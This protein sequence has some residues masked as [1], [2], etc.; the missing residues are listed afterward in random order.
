MLDSAQLAARYAA[1]RFSLKITLVEFENFQLMADIRVFYLSYMLIES[2]INAET[3]EPAKIPAYFARL[4]L[5]MNEE[6]QL[7]KRFIA[8]NKD[9]LYPAAMN[10]ENVLRNQ[11]INALYNRLARIR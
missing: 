1:M 5:L 7:D 9:V 2:G 3:A 6:P 8:L 11:K 10:Q 4:K